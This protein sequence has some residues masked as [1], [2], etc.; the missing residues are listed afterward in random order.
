MRTF[1]AQRGRTAP[2]PTGLIDIAISANGCMEE[3]VS[4]SLGKDIFLLVIAY[5][6]LLVYGTVALGRNRTVRNEAMLVFGSLTGVLLSVV[7][8]IGVCSLLGFPYCLPCQVLPFVMLGLGMDDAFIIINCLRHEPYEMHIKDSLSRA[9]SRAGAAITV[10]SVTDF[11]AFTLGMTSTLPALQYF[12]MY[13]AFGVL[14]DFILQVTF[15]CACIVFDDRRQKDGRPVLLCCFKVAEPVE[16]SRICGGRAPMH[17]QTEGGLLQKF[18]NT[19]LARV[20]QTPALRF[21]ML[22]G[23]AGIVAAC[24]WGA[25]KAEMGFNYERWMVPSDS[26]L[27]DAYDLKSEYYFSYQLPYDGLTSHCGNSDHLRPCV[28]YSGEPVQNQLDAM[29]AALRKSKWTAPGTLVSWHEGYRA[30]LASGPHSNELDSGGKAPT[31]ALWHA[32]L[33]EFLQTEEGGRFSTYVAFSADGSRVKASRMTAFTTNIETGTL[34]VDCMFGT[35]DAASAAAP[36]IGGTTS[37]LVF[38]FAEGLAVV[39]EQTTVAVALATV[40]IFCVSFVIVLDVT[41]AIMVVSCVV[42][43]DVQLMGWVYFMDLEYNSVTMVVLVVAVG[44][45]VDPAVHITHAFMNVSGSDRPQRMV[46]ALAHSGGG[47]LQG[48]ATTFSAVVVMSLARSYVF[49]VF[50][51]MFVGVCL[52]SFLNGCV[53]LPVVLSLV[54]PD[55]FLGVSPPR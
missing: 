31:S 22:F 27:W 43:T 50:S 16:E 28:D 2:S 37:S 17:A 6:T 8:S 12:C 44:L 47:I 45:T 32:W 21:G 10:T 40:A 13:A 3:E 36:L 18:A 35:R 19:V 24:A 39:Q 26:Y 25:T 55:P 48:I 1:A 9:M 53:F 14:F 34:Q 30:W 42:L 41:A 11:I 49:I 7:A 20:V 38:P 29:A 33:K 23:M 52:F 46:E 51:R 4:K 15:F 54:G 5:I